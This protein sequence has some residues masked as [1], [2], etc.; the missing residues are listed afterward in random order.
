MIDSYKKLIINS[1][2]FSVMS[3]FNLFCTIS[4]TVEKRKLAVTWK[5]TIQMFTA[6]PK[7]RSTPGFGHHNA[8]LCLL[9]RYSEK[10]YEKKATV[11]DYIQNSIQLF[12]RAIRLREIWRKRN[13]VCFRFN[14]ISHQRFEHNDS[15]F[16]LPVYSFDKLDWFLRVSWS[17]CYTQCQ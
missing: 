6:N 3:Y 14:R 4:I 11:T 8:C 13:L 1:S 7:R 9:F 12:K 5:N 2:V 17:D 16:R 10:A 15:I